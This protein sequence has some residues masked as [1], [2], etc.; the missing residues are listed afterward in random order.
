[1]SEKHS[2]VFY[3]SLVLRVACHRRGTHTDVI[4]STG[5]LKM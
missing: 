4:M 3:I 5:S 2:A 1:M